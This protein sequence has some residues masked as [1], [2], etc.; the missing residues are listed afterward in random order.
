MKKTKSKAKPI[1][2]KDVANSLLAFHL[3]VRGFLFELE[4][5]ILSV[6]DGRPD[7]VNYRNSSAV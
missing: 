2:A 7:T 3:T 6:S 1:T 4:L 5:K